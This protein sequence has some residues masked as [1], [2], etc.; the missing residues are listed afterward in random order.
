GMDIKEALEMDDFFE[1][2][3]VLGKEFIMVGK[4]RRNKMFN[5]LEFVVNSVKDVDAVEEANKIIS[6]LTTKVD[7]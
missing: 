6:S 1:N 4:V 3:N 7:L 2:I 5:R